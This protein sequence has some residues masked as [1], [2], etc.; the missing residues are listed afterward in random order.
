MYLFKKL[1]IK[2]LDSFWYWLLLLLLL[3]L[4][5]AII[6]V[7]AVIFD[8]IGFDEF[9]V[10]TMW[11]NSCLLI[12]FWVIYYLSTYCKIANEYIRNL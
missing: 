12:I 3:Y 1:V 6:V 10:I 9:S 11:C 8:V 5:M 4:D 2:S 7:P